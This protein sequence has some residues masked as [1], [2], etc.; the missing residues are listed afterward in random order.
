MH[1]GLLDRLRRPRRTPSGERTL[2]LIGLGNPGPR[3]AGDRHN[4]GFRCIDLLASRFDIALGDRR[5]AALIGEGRVH[6]GRV[7]LVEPRTFMNRSGEAVR[8]VLDR[9]RVGPASI[10]VI[11]DDLDLPVGRIRLRP[12]GGAGGHNGL[13]SITRSLGTDAYPRLRLGIGRPPGEA[14]E[15]VLTGFTGEEA[16]AFDRALERAADAAEEWVRHGI[17]YAMTHFN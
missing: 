2:A 12:G 10:L 14:V 9:F 6:G 3:H 4:A 17:E 11:L 7:V 16:P 13:H 5:R 8:Y 15:H 1:S